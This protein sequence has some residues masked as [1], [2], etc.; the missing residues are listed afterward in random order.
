MAVAHR[1]AVILYFFH[2]AQ[3]L[4]VGDDFLP[5]AF[6]VHSRIGPRSG[7]HLPLFIDHRDDL[8]VV[9]PPDFEVIGIVSRVT[10]TA[11]L[12]A[13]S[14]WHRLRQ[15]GP[16]ER[17]SLTVAPRWRAFIFWMNGHRC[18]PASIPGASWP[19]DVITVSVGIADMRQGGILSSCSTSISERAVWQR[20]HQL[21]I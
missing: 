11:R 6:P 16:V 20:G 19:D 2:Q 18:R 4:Q 13:G 10:F 1:M 8:Q 17:G 7:R 12:P 21:I 15:D 14:T 3:S 5:A 9:A